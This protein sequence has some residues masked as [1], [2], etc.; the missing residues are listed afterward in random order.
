MTTLKVIEVTLDKVDLQ[1]L[2]GVVRSMASREAHVEECVREFIDALPEQL[3]KD[4]EDP[5][6]DSAAEAVIEAVKHSH[7]CFLTVL[8]AVF[9][10]EDAVEKERNPGVK[11][12]GDT[13]EAVHGDIDFK[14]PVQ[15]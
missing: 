6:Q 3:A 7:E 2:R 8:T 14:A 4:F 5:H 9:A 13:L 10:N 1:F 11:E 15:K 12:L